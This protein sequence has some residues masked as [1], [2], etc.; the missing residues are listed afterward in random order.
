M[1]PRAATALFIVA[2]IIAFISQIAGVGLQ[3][4]ISKSAQET[5]KKIVLG[6]L[7][8]QLVLLCFFLANVAVF[9][10]RNNR[11]S[12]GLSDHPQIP[13]W[14][15]LVYV[16]YFSGVAIFVRNLVRAVEYGQGPRGMVATNEAFV[17]IFDAALILSPMILL[18]VWH[19]GYTFKKARRV[20]AAVTEATAEAVKEGL[21]AGRT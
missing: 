13:P 19:P 1:N 15:R 16:L 17:Y 9:H 3:A 20:D 21:G 12:S 10:V 4:S 8:F 5:G 14:R 6:G 2:D 18:V 7:V 11:N